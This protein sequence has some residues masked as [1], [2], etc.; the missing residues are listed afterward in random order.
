[1]GEEIDSKEMLKRKAKEVQEF[2]EF[3]VKTKVDK[4]E[5]RMTPRKK[6]W[7]KWTR[8]GSTYNLLAQQKSF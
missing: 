3:E 8:L 1:M 4:T 5:A 6:V 2:G 7:S